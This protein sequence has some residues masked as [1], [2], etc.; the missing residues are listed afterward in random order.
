MPMVGEVLDTQWLDVCSKCRTAPSGIADDGTISGNVVTAREERG[1]LLTSSGDLTWVDTPGKLVELVRG[2]DLGQF[3][4]CYRSTADSLIYGFVRERD[5][6]LRE[7][8]YPGAAATV[9]HTIDNAGGRARLLYLGSRCKNGMD[10][11]LSQRP[12]RGD[13]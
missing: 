4:G 7:I 3:V 6:R 8:S 12:I 13:V 9:A 1:F 11:L 2:N 5:G 10:L